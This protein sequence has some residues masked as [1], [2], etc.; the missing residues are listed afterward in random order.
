MRR[1][2]AAD[3]DLIKPLCESLDEKEEVYDD[4]YDAT[5]NPESK[6]LSFIAKVG[7]NAI[8]AFVC[9]KDINLSYYKSHFHI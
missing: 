3:L 1:A 8:G 9:S 4:I 5:I 7:D 2:V 6:Y